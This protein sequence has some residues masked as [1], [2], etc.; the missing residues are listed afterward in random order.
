MDEDAE[1]RAEFID[2]FKNVVNLSA[3]QSKNY[4]E[5]LINKSIGSI[6]LLAKRCKKKE[7]YL[8]DMGFDPD[9]IEDIT[10][11]LEEFDAKAKPTATRSTSEGAQL[12]PSQTPPPTPHANGEGR[13]VSSQQSF[14]NVH[15][16]TEVMGVLGE[17]GM[18]RAYHCVYAG[19]EV[20]AKEVCCFY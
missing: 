15:K 12:P 5:V 8:S 2:F 16:F 13:E 7:N 20:A 6:G 9:D 17:G 4:A 18:A 11:A 14:L 1:Q 10:E 3:K 19:T